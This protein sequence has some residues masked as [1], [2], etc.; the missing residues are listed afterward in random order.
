MSYSV[1]WYG[2][3]PAFF[4]FFHCNCWLYEAWNTVAA[5]VLFIKTHSAAEA[6]G[7][8][9]MFTKLSVGAQRDYG[10]AQLTTYMWYMRHLCHDSFI[11]AMT[12]LYVT[13]LI[14]ICCV[15]RL[16]LMSH[17]TYM[18]Y[19]CARH[20][21][22][23]WHI[24]VI[25]MCNTLHWVMAHICNIFGLW[26]DTH[27]KCEWSHICDICALTHSCVSWLMHMWRDSFTCDMSHTKKPE[28]F[29]S[30]RAHRELMEGA[31][32]FVAHS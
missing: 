9:C 20:C 27:N 26:F 5:I 23:S 15:C 31:T 21:D 24:Y 32:V 25:Y 14:H 7:D 10:A 17:G 22:E 16:T 29:L 19:I 4:S 18:W 2:V 13:W 11:R 1:Q 30:I 3:W 8:N 12:H 28:S 6:A